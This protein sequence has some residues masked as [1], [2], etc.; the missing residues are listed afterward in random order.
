MSAATATSDNV[1][2]STRIEHWADFRYLD[3]AGNAISGLL[4]GFT[5]TDGNETR[6]VLRPDGH[7][8]RDAISEG[9]CQAVLYAVTN[10]QW[11]NDAAE[12]GEK[13]KLSA[14]VLGFE[15]GTQAAIEI[16]RRD[17]TGPDVMIQAVE[18][19]VEGGKVETEWEYTLQMPDEQEL[20]E[21]E[22]EEQRRYSYPEYYFDVV[23]ENCKAHS[24]ILCYKDKLEFSYQDEDGNAIANK[25][26]KLF[27]SNGEVREGTL[28]GNGYAKVEDVPPGRI[29]IQVDPR[30]E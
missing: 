18:L 12:I 11:S 26:F 8:R 21:S 25:P 4:Y 14:E 19:E 10:A 27:L 20:E 17:I 3:N 23:V 5:D 28:D 29:R 16:Y 1:E 15:D 7:I 22:E 13:V 24:G 2:S 9:Q 6:G 30:K